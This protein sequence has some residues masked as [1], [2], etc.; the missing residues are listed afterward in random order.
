MTEKDTKDY[1]LSA[2]VPLDMALKIASNARKYNLSISQYLTIIIEEYFTEHEE[3]Q[4][5]NSIR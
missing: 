2:Y 4:N 3:V 5:D 1:R